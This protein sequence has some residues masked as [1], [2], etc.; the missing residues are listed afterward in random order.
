[1]CTIG[2]ISHL[3]H[4][5]EIPHH[6]RSTTSSVWLRSDIIKRLDPAQENRAARFLLPVSHAAQTTEKVVMM[7]ICQQWPQL[8]VQNH[9]SFRNRI[10]AA[11]SEFCCLSAKIGYLTG[12]KV[13]G[14]DSTQPGRFYMTGPTVRC[15]YCVLA[16]E[17]RLMVTHV[18]GTLIC[19][20]CGHTA[21][22]LDKHYECR[23]SKC[24]ELGQS[25]TV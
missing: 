23:C 19:G 20:K 25:K 9:A 15:P 16:N 12:A 13:T 2:V 8:A 22:P 18:D 21:R 1:V 7:M 24:R 17:F 4:I 3:W 14:L 11:A 5:W 10:M 6:F